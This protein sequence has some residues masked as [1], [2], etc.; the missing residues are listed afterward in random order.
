MKT[1]IEKLKKKIILQNHLMKRA[2][3]RYYNLGSLLDREA[4]SVALGK[5]EAYQVAIRLIEEEQDGQLPS[6]L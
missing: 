6:N 4:A 2:E 5:I 1:V 3:R